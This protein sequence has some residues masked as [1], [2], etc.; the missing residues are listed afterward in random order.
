MSMSTMAPQLDNIRIF[1]AVA[2]TA[3]VT[4][5]ALALGLAKSTVSDRIR[6]LEA[7]LNVRL[8][9]STTRRITLTESGRIYYERCGGVL[10]ALNA[11]NAEV[12]AM[13][14]RVTGTI[15][16][17]APVELAVHLLGPA[18]GQ[19]LGKNPAAKIHL[20]LGSENLDMVK[21]RMDLSLRIGTVHDQDLVARRICS[22]SRRAFASPAYIRR[23][24]MPLKPQDLV[25][26]Q[27]ILFP[28][29]DDQADWLFLWGDRRQTVTVA[30]PISVNSLGFVREAVVAGVGVGILPE[31]LSMDLLRQG[32]IVPVCGN[33]Q[34]PSLDVSIL[35]PTRHVLAK[36]RALIEFLVH[37]V[38]KAL[39]EAGAS[40]GPPLGAAIES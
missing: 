32:V 11:A 5:A 15:R 18:I 31:L 37:Q 39:T 27:C 30:G 35:T 19:F 9:S 25:R 24:G 8:I 10:A 38:P 20:H 36:T 40:P 26:H 29:V 7:Q 13:Q 22:V 23:Y 17:S 4:K 2:E 3:S 14:T 33:W 6:D 12:S 21:E 34:A 1:V 28:H 16:V